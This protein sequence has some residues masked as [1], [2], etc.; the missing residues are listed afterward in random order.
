MEFLMSEK[1]CFIGDCHRPSMARGLCVNC[2]QAARLRVNS[3]LVTWEQLEQAGLSKPKQKESGPGNGG[4]FSGAFDEKF[5]P[6]IDPD[7][8]AA[9]HRNVDT[10]YRAAAA[11]AAGQPPEFV[12]PGG[13]PVKP[14]EPALELP[15]G[16]GPA[17]Q[18][19]PHVVL[20][21]SPPAEET[22]IPWDKQ[23]S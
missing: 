15:E 18:A 12:T 20:E 6:S 13:Q 22:T 16:I 17:D 14:A 10:D 5:Q 1:K 8:D 2:Y 11:E 4:K 21:E 23:E 9:N 3:G 19:A 7:L